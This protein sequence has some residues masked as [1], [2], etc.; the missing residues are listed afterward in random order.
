LN[1]LLL[2]VVRVAVVLWL[3]A[4]VLVDIEQPQD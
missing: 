3:A 2:Q 1:T 4:A